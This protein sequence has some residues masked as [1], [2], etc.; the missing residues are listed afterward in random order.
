MVKSYRLPLSIS[1]GYAVYDKETD[2]D[3]KSVFR[4]ADEAMYQD[5]TDYYL[6]NGGSPR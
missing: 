4:R 5:K 3:L 6:H 1:K 2:A